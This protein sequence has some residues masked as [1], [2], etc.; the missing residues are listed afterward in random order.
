MLS[1]GKARS[2]TTAIQ[3]CKPHSGEENQGLPG[4]N[5]SPAAQSCE[6]AARLIL[7]LR[8]ISKDYAWRILSKRIDGDSTVV[9]SLVITSSTFENLDAGKNCRPCSLICTPLFLMP[10]QIPNGVRGL[11]TTV[12]LLQVLTHSCGVD[13]SGRSIPW[14]LSSH[15]DRRSRI[16]TFGLSIWGKWS[17]MNWDDDYQILSRKAMLACR[18]TL[19]RWIIPRGWSGILTFKWEPRNLRLVRISMPFKRLPRCPKKAKRIGPTPWKPTK[20]QWY[21]SMP[22]LVSNL[23]RAEL[24]VKGWQAKEAVPRARNGWKRNKLQVRVPRLWGYL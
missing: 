19:L 24:F 8:A 6:I 14:T 7:C 23:A 12:C 16:R 2:R 10:M 9:D 13:D 18:F 17:C 1:S 11:R 21:V 20:L 15:L 4:G 3:Q 5:C 22:A